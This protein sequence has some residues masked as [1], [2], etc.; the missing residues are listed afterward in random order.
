V[1]AAYIESYDNRQRIHS[2]L[3]YQTPERMVHNA[4]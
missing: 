1:F 3:G 4:A 2:A